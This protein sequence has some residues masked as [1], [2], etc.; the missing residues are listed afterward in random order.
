MIT[1]FGH[2]AGDMTQRSTGDQTQRST[3]R[4]GGGGTSSRSPP[5][6]QRGGTS[7]ALVL[8]VGGLNGVG[9]GGETY[10]KQM[11]K[12][13]TQPIGWITVMKEGKRFV[14]LT[15]QLSAGAR[16]QHMQAWARRLAVDK[17][18]GSTAVF[19]GEKS[20]HAPKSP[21]RDSHG[22]GGVV[23]APSRFDKAK[24]FEGLSKKGQNELKQKSR[25]VNRE[26]FLNEL[27]S[28][29][30]GIGFAYGGVHP[31]KLH[32]HGKLLP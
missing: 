13:P 29:P 9:G 12:Q 7:S 25:T 24:S 32:A 31:G 16:Q 17:A 30:L 19:L 4:G 15:S 23:T 28:D 3:A 20:E 2:V 26:R 1:A 6:T 21:N 8:S 5:G 11:S 22:S 10:R 14:T 27:N 18:I